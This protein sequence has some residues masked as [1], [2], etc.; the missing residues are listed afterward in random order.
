ME[1]HYDPEETEFVEV[2][3]LELVGGIEDKMRLR[4]L[5]H[6]PTSTVQHDLLPHIFHL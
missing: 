3:N 5:E 2:V 1:N 4:V 6:Y